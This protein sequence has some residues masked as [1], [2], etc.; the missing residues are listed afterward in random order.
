MNNINM[1][2]NIEMKIYNMRNSYEVASRVQLAK[3]PF[4]RF[5]GLMFRPKF[6]EQSAL[7]IFPCKAIHSFFMCFEFDVVF[8]NA[9]N[10]VVFTVRSMKKNSISKTIKKASGVLELPKGTIAKADIRI[11][12]NLQ[13]K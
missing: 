6:P 7:Y 10:E 12:D 11:G 1:W 8:L 4:E 3:T 5:M 2:Y 9:N 13:F